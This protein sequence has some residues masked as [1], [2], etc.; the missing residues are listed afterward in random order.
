MRDLNIV[1]DTADEDYAKYLLATISYSTLVKGLKNTV[2]VDADGKFL[3]PVS[4]YQVYDL[5]QINHAVSSILLKNI[6]MFEN[7][8]KTRMAKLVSMYFSDNTSLNDEDE[9]N[10]DDFFCKNYYNSSGEARNK[11]IK[12][13][14]KIRESKNMVVKHYL[15]DK[16]YMPPWIAVNALYFFHMRTWYKILKGKEKMIIINSSLGL[17]TSDDDKKFQFFSDILSAIYYSRNHLAHGGS[18]F[19]S[20]FNES[21]QRDILKNLTGGIFEIS[22]TISMTYTLVLCFCMVFKSE[23]QLLRQLIVD[24]RIINELT[25]KDFNI[26]GLSLFEILQLPI[27]ITDRIEEFIDKF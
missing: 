2:F 12:L 7:H 25:F 13:R 23:K 6:L 17:F 15:N 1:I 5:V 16:T 4:I 22:S 26:C 18:I 14:K 10:P 20:D 3:E 27:D 19:K 8:F 24:L 9:D 21:L 11:L